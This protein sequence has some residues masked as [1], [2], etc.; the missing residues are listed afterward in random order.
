MSLEGKQSYLERLREQLWNFNH[1]G[2]L[3]KAAEV[4]KEIDQTKLDISEFFCKVCNESLNGDETVAI[5]RISRTLTW[6]V[7]AGC[8]AEAEKLRFGY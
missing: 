2:S 1:S 5:F 8:L 6:S 3:I 7:H 4:Q